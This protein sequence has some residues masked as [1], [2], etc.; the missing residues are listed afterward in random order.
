MNN[1]EKFADILTSGLSPDLKYYLILFAVVFVSTY[2]GSYLREYAKSRGAQYATKADL[3][4]IHE[5]LKTSTKISETIKNEVEHGAWQKREREILKREKLEQ[6][7]LNHY[8]T[9]KTLPKKMRYNLFYHKETWS[10]SSESTAKMLQQL[11]LP[12]LDSEYE[13]FL[14]VNADFNSWLA[15][16]QKQLVKRMQAGEKEPL[17]NNEHME[18]FS[19]LL[20]RTNQATL[21]IENKARDISR[22]MNSINN[23][24]S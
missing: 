22:E 3:V 15:K 10:E 23:E 20:D 18:L 14:R 21:A 13:Q 7:L 9:E 11:Y 1:T 17:P 2:L 12:E 16:G 24:L 4:E 6:F 8:E 5:Q 19:D